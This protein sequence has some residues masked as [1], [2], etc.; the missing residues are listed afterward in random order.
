MSIP[1]SCTTGPP[2]SDSPQLRLTFEGGTICLYGLSEPPET[3]PAPL[4]W[5][6]RQGAHRAPAMA[7]A[8]VVL[9][10][11]NQCLPFTD[12]AR[13]YHKLPPSDITRQRPFPYQSEAI[14]AWESHQGRG[15]VVLPTGSGKTFVAMLAMDRRPRSTLIVVPTLDLLNQWYDELCVAFSGPVGIIG[16][17]Y[18]EPLDLTVITYDS[19]HLHMDHLG[20]RYGMVVF[21]ECHHLPSEGYAMAARACLAPF[22][23]GLTAT[24]E[25]SDGFEDLYDELIGPVVYRKDIDELSGSYLSSYETLRLEVSLTEA[26]R[27]EYEAERATYLAFLRQ[28]QIRMSTPS[29]WRDFIIRSSRSDTGRRAMGAYRRQ[30][31]LALAAEGKIDVLARLLH[32]H[33]TDR[34]I[35]FTEDNATVYAIAQRFLVPAI[36]HQT[37]VKERRAILRAFNE[38]QLG[39]VVTS[40]VLNEGV[41][42][43]EANVAIVLSGSGS[44]REHVQR[45]GRILRKR[46]GK[47]AVLYEVVSAG[48][49]EERTSAKRR[50]H[51]AYQ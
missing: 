10:L 19:A 5:D 35:I 27:A 11:R 39:A 44:V 13:S 26:E 6:D 15:V 48:T 12:D 14:T 29:G 40:K 38:V 17:G 36:T 8:E 7:Y 24:P 2:M 46:A 33:R 41:N 18:H 20:H 22:R 31:Q 9:W 51:R 30:R 49:A 1:L 16:G 3:M 43:P 37:K 4:L 50:E 34:A 47:R 21:D 45:L 42:V 23:L 32:A 28:Q 25:R